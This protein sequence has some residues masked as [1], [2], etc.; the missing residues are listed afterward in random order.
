VLFIDADIELADP[1]LIRRAVEL[2]RTKS[3]HCL[4]TDILCPDGSFADRMLKCNNLAQRLSRF[5]KPFATGMFMLVD[6]P[7]F[8]ELGGFDEQALYAEDYQLTRQFDRQRSRSIRGGIHSTNRRF[9]KMGHGKILRMFL[10][11]AIRS[12][13]PEYFRDQSHQAYWKAY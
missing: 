2:M 1:M 3:L 8:D 12:R 11:T 4:T 6:K 13:C 7:R 9:Q 10:T 5:H